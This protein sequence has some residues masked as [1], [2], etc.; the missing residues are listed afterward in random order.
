M[1]DPGKAVFLSYASQDAEA[2]K[3]I[4]EALRAA[5]IEV[6]FDLSE[7]R[8]GDAWDAK[9]RRQIKE[10]T[11][12]VPLITPNTNARPEGYFRLE[13]KLAVD[14]SHL[15]ADDQP[16]LFPIVVGDVADA[17]AR[18]P[19]KFRDVQWT[20]LRLDETPAELAARVRRL[21]QAGEQASPAVAG[22]AT[23]GAPRAK[24][25]KKGF[26]QWW[27]LIFPIM[28]MSVPIIGMLKGMSP[29]ET[30]PA[31]AAQAPAVSEARRLAERALGMIEL[32]DSNPDDFAAAE[33]L[34]KRALEMDATDG[35]IWA[36][37]SRI[38]SGYLTRGFERGGARREAARSQAERAVKLAPDSPEAWLAL[39][40]GI[41]ST[42]PARAEE[43]YRHG[44]T[45][46]PQ[47]GRLLLGL[48]SIH[49]TTG[50]LDEALAFY[51]KAAQHPPSKA[52]ALYDQY[53]IHFYQRRFEQADRCLRES[54]S[55]S[56]STNMVAGLAMLAVTWKGD[57]AG[58]RQALD[59]APSSM[60]S[61]PRV[62]L[63]SALVNLMARRPDDALQALDR[64]PA[65]Y[66]NDA[67][68][69][70][71]KALLTGLAHAEAGRAEA[72]RIAWE[73]GL[74][75][76]RRRLQEQPNDFES[77]LRLGELLARVGQ[78]EAALQEA[79]I[80]TE[81]MRDRPIDWT[82]SVA[83]IY[84]ALGQV[85]EAVPQLERL[86]AAPANA[87]NRWPL[88]PA[89]LR[90]DPL[91]DKLR[92]DVRFQRLII[93]NTPPREWPKNPELKRAVG[94]LDGLEMI[95]EDFRLAEEIAQRE[96]D[97][98]P[99]DPEA[100]TVVARVH[101]M[102]L[103]RGW[104]RST[105]RYQKAKAAAERALQL[106]PD[107]PEAQVALAIHLYARGTQ[108]QHALAL[109]QRAVE[110]AP[111]EP[112]FHRMRDN[113]LWVM[114]VPAGS[115]FADKTVDLENEGLNRALAS[116]Q[117]TVELFPK[118]PLVRYE[119]SRHYR[120]IGRWA[121][122]ER[123]N[124][125]VLALAPLANAMVWKA[126]ARFGLHGD[127]PGMKAVLD[128]VPARVRGI[129][130]TVFGYFLYAAFTGKASVGLD[131]LNVMTDPW[132]IDFDYRGPKALLAGALQELNGK[133]ELARV[134]YEVA[135]TDLLRARSLNPEDNQT[136]LNEAWIQ[137]ALGRSEAARAALR[138]SNESLARPF[139]VSPLSTWWFQPIAA[140]LLIGDRATALML[141]QE[142]CASRADG[143]ATIR[144]RLALDPRLAAF[145]DDAEIQALLAE[146]AGP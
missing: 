64:L 72:A 57:V 51:E 26:E 18:V 146:P 120:D 107:E 45:L 36:V 39:G 24:P 34:I 130:R 20:R 75:V 80:C 73:S 63:T 86:L 117:R 144:Q 110:L 74:P 44:L 15:M 49:R 98:N 94:L 56:N 33:A 131:A 37:S 12:F 48:G 8:G 103:L 100:V 142:G 29:R 69:T 46:A 121:D 111:Q 114:H 14:R 5:G 85:D 124:D 141:I 129:E 122:F 54:I 30:K 134:Q 4:C 84:A 79:R 140:N 47:D 101:S 17:T 102:W 83:R 43:A 66:I 9:I 42:D 77:H 88:S 58:A 95:P 104:D 52:L 91:W 31:P 41:G 53:L 92:E 96:L 76:V 132:M 113:C 65:D 136:Y 71:P 11:L 32:I 1:S 68:F 22:P 50:R 99:A 82:S 40:R 108:D 125:E 135:L 55:I 21:L 25:E 23:G 126:R 81:L 87:A 138:I 38:N 106:A 59:H 3:R 35:Y 139:S 119:L 6:W 2:A 93:A 19:D 70:G 127:L 109:A 62:V 10:C 128:Q 90:L 60:R 67:W 118:D 116:A 115:V 105:A 143:R 61:Q 16:F 13:W 28:G 27:W 133:K 137:H 89:L 97:K 112:R 123:V 145:R 7:L 78:T